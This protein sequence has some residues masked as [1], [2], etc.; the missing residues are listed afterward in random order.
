MKQEFNKLENLLLTIQKDTHYL[1]KGMLGQPLKELEDHITIDKIHS[2]TIT[3][4]IELQDK[5]IVLCSQDKS[6]TVYS[7]NYDE[8]K[9]TQ[10]FKQENAHEKGIYDIGEISTNT[11]VS[12][13]D[14]KNIKIWKINQNNLELL[15]N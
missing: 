15:S 6:I 1:C 14:D 3:S 13:S 11:L 7:I 2:N 8:K 9:W 4:I 5:R 12:V 10:D